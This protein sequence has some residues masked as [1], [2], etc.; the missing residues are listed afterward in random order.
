[1]NPLENHYDAAGT[2][3][4]FCE[5]CSA[6]QRP[7]HAGLPYKYT[8]LDSGSAGIRLLLLHPAGDFEAPIAASLYHA[9][10]RDYPTYEALSYVWGDQTTIVNV[11]IHGAY[12]SITQILGQALR[13]LRKRHGDRLLW[14][15]ALCIDQSSPEE[16]S[17]Q[18]RLMRNIYS[19]CTA[20]LVWIGEDTGPWTSLAYDIAKRLQRSDMES[21]RRRV[22]TLNLWERRELQDIELGDASNTLS[23]HD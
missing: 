1:M 4:W 19:S 3:T 17:A 5:P 9:D 21:L 2:L 6:Q 18:V 15:D 16:R 10:L 7:V 11:A 13:R 20:D 14:I 22:R 12:V 8:P 23:R